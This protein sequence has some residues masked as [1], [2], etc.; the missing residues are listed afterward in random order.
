MWNFVD[1]LC[2]LNQND[3]FNVICA[4]N[5]KKKKKKKKKKKF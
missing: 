3:S 4:L 1:M 2:E 5:A